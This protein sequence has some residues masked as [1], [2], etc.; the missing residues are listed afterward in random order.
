MPWTGLNCHS[1]NPP[2]QSHATGL[3]RKLLHICALEVTRIDNTTR[4]PRFSAAYL[5]SF[6]MHQGRAIA[7]LLVSELQLHTPQ[8]GPREI[9]VYT[10]V[11]RYSRER[12]GT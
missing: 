9:Q 12:K 10:G 3:L 7:E 6:H 8:G 5:P 4:Y 1:G 2:C 11:T